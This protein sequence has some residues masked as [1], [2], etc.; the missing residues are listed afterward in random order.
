MLR[1]GADLVKELG[2]IHSFMGW[3][4]PIL[5]DS[6]GFQAH[7]LSKLRKMSEEGI[8]FRSPYDGNK[9]FLSPE[10]A[11]EV[12]TDLG[13]DIMMCLDECTKYPATYEE[14]KE[15]MELTHKWALRCKETW[16][17]GSSLLFGIAQGGVYPD[18]RRESAKT[19][20]DL[21]LPGYAL[22]GLALGE[23]ADL[24]LAA[25]EA[26]F[27]ELPVDKPRY[28]MGMGTPLDILNG[29]K[30]GA[31]MFDCVLPTRNA[32]NGQFFTKFGTLNILNAR[33]KRDQEPIDITCSCYTCQN[34]SKSYLRHLYQNREPLFVRLATLHNLNF[35][36]KTLEGARESLKKGLFMEYSKQFFKYYI[37]DKG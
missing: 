30:R 23:P 37:S 7:S 17:E 19:L 35:Y 28:L 6:G 36:L 1:P 3:K 25:I 22:G 2:G 29:I 10:R 24:R 12:Q 31:D 4:G 8:T 14:S 32:R 15:S 18:L 13:V 20:R 33:F 21:D 9:A 16:R 5:T 11:I 34:F 26:G 27:S